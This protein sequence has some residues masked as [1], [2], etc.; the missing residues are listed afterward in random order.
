[1]C[2]ECSKTSSPPKLRKLNRSL[3]DSFCK[4]G[5]VSVTLDIHDI[6]SM[7]LYQLTAD[8]ITEEEEVREEDEVTIPSVEMTHFQGKDISP[9][10]P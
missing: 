1:M 6:I 5:L 2:R 3:L 10:Q 8:W 4:H 9:V 7:K